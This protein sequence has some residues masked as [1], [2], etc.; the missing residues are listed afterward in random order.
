MKRESL[1][2]SPVGRLVAVLA[3]V[4]GVLAC[5]PRGKASDPADLRFIDAMVAHHQGAIDMARVAESSAMHV[6]LRDFARKIVSDQSREVEMMTGWR[7]AWFPGSPRSAHDMDVPG[8]AESMRGMDVGRLKTLAGA[9]FD[10]AFLDA[11]IPHHQGA[12][13]MAI[14]ALTRSRR[15]ELRKL[16][17]DI[18]DA[19]R[20]EVAMMER[21]RADWGPGR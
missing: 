12:V 19:Q 15:P 14:D 9:E 18:I 8:M 3:V 5:A 11:M 20:A 17:Q 13:A 2:R 21:W 7:Q 10:R 16:A 1:A 4:A 6:E